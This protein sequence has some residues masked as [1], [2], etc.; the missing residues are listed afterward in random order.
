MTEKYTT[1]R[2]WLLSWLRDT[3]W[4]CYDRLNYAVLELLFAFWI[5]CCVVF[6]IFHQTFIRSK[7]MYKIPALVSLDLRF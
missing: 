7:C 1:Q 3:V 4:Q 6:V 5:G 2:Q